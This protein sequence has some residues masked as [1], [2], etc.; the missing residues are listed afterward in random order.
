MKR[1][2]RAVYILA[3]AA[4]CGAGC[5]DAPKSDTPAPAPADAKAAAPTAADAAATTDT[6]AIAAAAAPVE[7]AAQ[8]QKVG[9]WGMLCADDTKDAGCRLVQSAILNMPAKEGAEARSHRVMLTVVSYIDDAADPVLTV[10]V[11][12][13]IFL[14]PGMFLDVEGYDQL[15]LVPQFCDGNG[16]VAVLPMKEQL[17]EAFKKKEEARITFYS[18]TGKTSGVRISL[19]GFG[20]ALATL[21]SKRKPS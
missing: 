3:L 8:P 2:P 21:G 16:C 17:V 9:D 6:D 11:P 19:A 13:G 15:R 1:G 4:L 14:P 5:A 18:A 10:V 20:D 7:D 12:L